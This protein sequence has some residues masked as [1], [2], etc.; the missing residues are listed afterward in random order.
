MSGLISGAHLQAKHA[1][2]M[3]IIGEVAAH[4]RWDMVRTRARA[5]IENEGV[6][7]TSLLLWHVA[8]ALTFEIWANDPDV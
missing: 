4:A 2:L 8:E 7:R 1:F 5:L 3:V 6:K